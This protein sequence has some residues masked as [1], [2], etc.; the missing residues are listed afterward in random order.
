MHFKKSFPTLYPGNNKGVSI[1]NPLL[2]PLPFPLLFAYS[3]P[4]LPYFL[5]IMREM[6]WEMHGECP[7]AHIIRTIVVGLSHQ[8]QLYIVGSFPQ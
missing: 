6:I 8:R 5:D 2:F 4:L 3:N 1:E 7:T